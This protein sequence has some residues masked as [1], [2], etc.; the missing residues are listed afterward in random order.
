MSEIHRLF[1]E[2]KRPVAANY[3]TSMMGSG[4][5]PKCESDVF[6]VSNLFIMDTLH[7]PPRVMKS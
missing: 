5:W 7:L 6:E 2:P 4:K 3:P 1:G